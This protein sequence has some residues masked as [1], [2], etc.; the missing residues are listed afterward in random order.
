M[1]QS[2]S[3]E[4]YVAQ[5]LGIKMRRAKAL[6]QQHNG[7][8]EVAIQTYRKATSTLSPAP[9][10]PKTPIISQ[11]STK[12]VL[13][14][15]VTSEPESDSF[16]TQNSQTEQDASLEDAPASFTGLDFILPNLDAPEMF[17][18]GEPGTG[19]L[20]LDAIVGAIQDG[21]STARVHNYLT[22]YNATVN[23][24]KIN[25][26]VAGVPAMF[27][28]VQSRDVSM[29][30]LWAKY[31][32]DVN[33]TATFAPLAGVPL[34]VF[35]A[36]LGDSFKN[37]ATEILTTLISLGASPA[38]IPRAFYSPFQRDL[39]VDGPPETE[40]PELEEQ[41]MSWCVED[42]RK[43]LAARLN[44]RQRYYL[45]MASMLQGPGIR[46][47][48]V[49]AL[50]DSD[51]LLGIP[52]FLIGQTPA[53]QFLI[54]RLV[55]LLARPSKVPA[56]MVFAGPS[57]HGKTELARKL[58]ELLSL[59]MEIVDCTSKENDREMFGARNPYQGWEN[60][61][62]LN[63]FLVRRAGQRCIVFLD[64]FEKTTK[65]VHQTLLLPFQNGRLPYVRLLHSCVAF[66]DHYTGEYE[67]RRTR[68]TIDSAKTIWI[69]A[70][71]AFDDTIHDFCKSN[72]T[73]LCHDGDPIK[74]Q[75][76]AKKLCKTLREESI[77][78]FGAPLTGRITDFVP[79]LTFSKGEQACVAHKHLTEVGKEMAK[80]LV[81]SRD[82]TTQRFIGDI[83]MQ[84]PRDYSICQI[85]AQEEYLEQLGARSVINGV[86][87]LIEDPILDHFLGIESAIT[88]GQ[89]TTTY[90]VEA[91]RDHDIE[92]CYAGMTKANEYAVGN[93]AGEQDGTCASDS[94][95][96]Q[97][98]DSV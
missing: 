82:M 28:V 48:Q 1:T 60:G 11:E 55:R 65:D 46:A 22:S 91:N 79:F 8:A 5:A 31:G 64:E 45:N 10:R 59:D 72:E 34:L 61:S 14:S 75:D 43:M 44:L 51:S 24:S 92:I 73:V 54:R 13:P 86:H 33:A 96:S 80:S 81:V 62:P 15:P 7:E 3:D 4:Q 42:A 88:E 63:N 37:D 95:F 30:R 85:I 38:S 58:G 76:R 90:R 2:L 40:L 20:M 56:I 23:E 68:A 49:T 52:Y 71:N 41:H 69:L 18:N 50:T 57:G 35:A 94:A 21:E 97:I 98:E 70:T 66:A 53:A 67:D 83:D 87:R 29:I 78:E 93:A 19:E 17:T 39:P 47:R 6:L 12:H 9:K 16:K 77:G 25:G 32:G 84:V 89:G 36:G 26:H 74:A 27:Y